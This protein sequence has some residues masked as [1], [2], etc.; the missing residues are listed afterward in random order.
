MSDGSATLPK[1][2]ALNKISEDI[3]WSSEE[4]RVIMDN[5]Q[6]NLHLLEGWKFY[7][8]GFLA[9]EHIGL[10]TDMKEFTEH[11]CIAKAGL[12]E[13]ASVLDYVKEVMEKSFG[14]SNVLEKLF[15]LKAEIGDELHLLARCIDLYGLE[16]YKVYIDAIIYRALLQC[17]HSLTT[18][19]S[20]IDFLIEKHTEV[21][22]DESAV[23]RL[24][25][26]L[27]KY[28]EVDYQKLNLSLSVAYRC[29]HRIA[30]TLCEKQLTNEQTVEYWLTN[31]FVRRFAE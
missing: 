6:K 26:M 25:L 4:M 22:D 9:R 10:L 11:N 2:L 13:Y 14:S 21:L 12:S 31:D 15:D 29:M 18:I 30:E 24:N 16:K 17:E 8:D 19:L 23:F 7:A 1:Y 5:L 27:D 20:F 3:T 28:V